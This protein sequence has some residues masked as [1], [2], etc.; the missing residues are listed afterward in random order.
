MAEEKAGASRRDF[1]KLAAAGAPAAAVAA[2]AG[3]GEA[4]AAAPGGASAG[5]RKTAHVEKYLETARF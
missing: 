4:E 2:A 5:L 1:L 3:G